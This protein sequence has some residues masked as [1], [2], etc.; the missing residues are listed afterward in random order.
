MNY[1]WSF[2][3]FKFTRNEAVLASG[4][5]AVRALAVRSGAKRSVAVYIPTTIRRGWPNAVN[6][7]EAVPAC[8]LAVQERN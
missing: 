6:R 3:R 5:R 4:T 7:V 2:I 1:S 8:Y